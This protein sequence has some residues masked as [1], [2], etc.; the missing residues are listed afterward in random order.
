MVTLWAERII[1]GKKTFDQVPARL[2]TQV[3]AV[4][5]KCGRADL[6]AAQRT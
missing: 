6:V 4:L 2:K 1:L 3:K 5:E